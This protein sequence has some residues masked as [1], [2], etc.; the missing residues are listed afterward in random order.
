MKT[1]RPGQVAS[2][3]NRFESNAIDSKPL[4]FYTWSPELLRV[5][6]FMRYFQQPLPPDRPDLISDLA[7][8]VGSDPKLLEDY[9]R[10]ECV[11]RP[12]HQ[13]GAD[14]SLTDVLERRGTTERPH[15]RSPSSRALDPRKRSCL[16]GCS[17]RALPPGADLMKEMIRGH[18][19]RPGRPDSRPGQRLVRLSDPRP[20]DASAPGEGARERQAPADQGLQE[21]DAR[22]LSGFDDQAQ[23]NACPHPGGRNRRCRSNCFRGRQVKPRLRVEPCPTYYLRTARSYDF[24]LNFLLAAVGEDGLASLHGLQAKGANGARPCS[25]SSA[26][27]GSC[28]TASIC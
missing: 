23:G 26:G 11:L 20:G 22:G 18:P 16:A 21:A 24:L 27:C 8:A 9:K 17:Q 12:T 7:R 2:W 5:F 10:R 13:P 6:R 14:L 28:S 4:G 25:K 19:A 3:L 1:S 15:A